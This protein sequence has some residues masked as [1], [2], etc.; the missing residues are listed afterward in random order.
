M[1]KLTAN[2]HLLT[3][4]CLLS[5]SDTLGNLECK[6]RHTETANLRQGII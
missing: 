6:Q 5:R 4:F 3:N 1:M 2:T